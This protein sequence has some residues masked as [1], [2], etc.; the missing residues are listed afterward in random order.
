MAAI[1]Q[2]AQQEINS[3]RDLD[4]SAAPNLSQPGQ[5]KVKQKAIAFAVNDLR[6]TTIGFAGDYELKVDIYTPK[7]LVKPA[8]LAIIAHGLGS[9]RSDF[10]YLGN[11][12]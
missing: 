7:A 6:Q 9:E 1:A 8:P 4:L 5:Y 10:T 12:C 11:L 2:Q 3:Q